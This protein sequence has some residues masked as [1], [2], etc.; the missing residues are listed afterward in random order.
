MGVAS[1]EVGRFLCR[2]FS[3]KGRGGSTEG[4]RSHSKTKLLFWKKDL[5]RVFRSLA[6][7][8]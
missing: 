6:R 2:Y 4:V 7:E 5:R 8:V 3:L 1:S